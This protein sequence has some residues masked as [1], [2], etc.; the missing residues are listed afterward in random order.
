MIRIKIMGKV[1]PI[2]KGIFFVIFMVSSSYHKSFPFFVGFEKAVK[3][4][5]GAPGRIRTCVARRQRVYSA[6]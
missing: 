4:Y 5:S 2:N 1:M 3:F 6:S